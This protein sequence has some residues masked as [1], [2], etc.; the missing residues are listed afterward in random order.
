LSNLN[1]LP[2]ADR[3]GDPRQQPLSR[4]SP[5]KRRGKKREETPVEG[6][7]PEL[8]SEPNE[9]REKRDSGKIVDILI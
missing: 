5:N 3:L 4:E 6:T 8:E 1:Q 9:D 2:P 7:E